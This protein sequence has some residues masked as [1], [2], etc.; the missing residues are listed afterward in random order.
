VTPEGGESGTGGNWITRSA[1]WVRGISRR[2][3]LRTKLV[4]AVL[5][6]V[7]AALVA[8]SIASVWILRS[9]LT[10]QDDTTLT[11]A[12]S[13]IDTSTITQPGKLYPIRGFSNLYVGIQQ[14]GS[15]LSWA[16]GSGVGVGGGQTDP[17][18]DLPTSSGWAGSGTT[19]ITAPAESGNQTWRVFATT[20][21][22]QVLSPSGTQAET[23]TLVVAA[24]LGDIN[25]TIRRVAAFD[26]AISAAIVLALAVVGVAV[27][28]ANLRPL[29]EIEETA[30]EIAAGHLNRRVRES[31]PHTEVGSLAQSLNIM[32]SQIETAFRAQQASEEAAHQSEER[33]RRFIADASHELRTPLTAIRGFAEYYRQ[34]GGVE[35]AEE[36]AA[37]NGSA[38]EHLTA[39]DLDRIMHRV[40][41]EASRMGLL[42]EDLLMLA[43]LDQQRPLS[44]K[45]V[46]LLTLAADSVQDGRMIA[47][48]RAIDLQVAP[49][50]AFIVDGDEA[51]LR[52]VITNLV[53]NA[54]THTPAG[55]PVTVRIASGALDSG[56]PAVVLEVV[57][58]GPGLTPEQAQ[59]VFD[60]FYRADTA[61]TRATGGSGLGLSIVS[62]LVA[63]HGGDVAVR[64]TPGEGA[65]FR[66]RLPLV[67]EA[68]AA[69][70]SDDEDADS[71]V[72]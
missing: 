69:A 70:D 47:P 19:A 58:R 27:V 17:L 12:I 71:G 36:L 50:A 48:D 2:T 35:T 16:N 52:Q 21:Q 6:L 67:A 42:V 4:T 14:S 24:D 60:R 13:T 63:A 15:Q 40:E 23:G 59:H 56:K 5:G 46:D 34:R 33:M 10:T 18:P 22:Y 53:N 30:E 49:G 11:Q 62:S 8:I 37:A 64:S 31:D 1:R 29:E 72:F 41:A 57:D 39:E 25:Q 68:H 26:I 44:I 65:T 32:L 51:R 9:Y 28:R 7:I 3:S 20:Y 38:G 55:T 61:R 54:L 66:V 45:P 43:R